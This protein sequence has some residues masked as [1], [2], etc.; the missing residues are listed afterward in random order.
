MLSAIALPILGVVRGTD[1]LPLDSAIQAFQVS[2]PPFWQ[3]LAA[4]DYMT[5]IPAL[6]CMKLAVC[7]VFL[8][9]YVYSAL[10]DRK[11]L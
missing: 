2:L 5:A 6:C 1:G 11:M 3:L 10:S 4:L 8:P 7:L 9:T